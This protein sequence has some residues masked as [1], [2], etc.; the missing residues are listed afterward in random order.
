[1]IRKNGKMQKPLNKGQEPGIKGIGSGKIK[2]P[3][4]QSTFAW[5]HGGVVIRALD[6]RSEVQQFEAQSM[7]L[8][9]FF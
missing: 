5:G 1:M 9:C 3:S 8:C 4:P 2:L 6:F 7:P